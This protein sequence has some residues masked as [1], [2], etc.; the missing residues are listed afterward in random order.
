MYLR[1]YRQ[2]IA[3]LFDINSN[4]FDLFHGLVNNYFINICYI[5]I[6]PNILKGS[7]LPLV[8]IS[9]SAVRI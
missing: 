5:Y 8:N 1:N 4:L 2:F 6:Y 3:S 7:L 9:N